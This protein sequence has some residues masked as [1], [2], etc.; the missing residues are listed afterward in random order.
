M[1]EYVKRDPKRYKEIPAANIR[2][3]VAPPG[4]FLVWFMV[5]TNYISYK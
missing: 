4:A 3:R 2:Q 1:I 5:E